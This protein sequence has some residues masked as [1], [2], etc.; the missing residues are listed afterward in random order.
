MNFVNISINTDN[1]LYAHLSHDS[2]IYIHSLNS[3]VVAGSS[4]SSSRSLAG[5]SNSVQQPRVYVDKNHLT[6]SFT[7]FAWSAE[8]TTSSSNDSKSTINSN[9]LVVG[10]SDGMIIVWD[11]SRGVI[12]R[13]IHGE[14]VV[15]VL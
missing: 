12:I 10:C 1:T 7:C 4:S 6:H 14:Y 5:S 11:L 9:L 13:T 15:F 2:R 3:N 8:P